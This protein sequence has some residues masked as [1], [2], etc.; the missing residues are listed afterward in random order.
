[1]SNNLGLPGCPHALR[2]TRTEFTWAWVGRDRFAVL[3]AYAREY[4]DP[5]F[6]A[7]PSRA[8]PWLRASAAP[9]RR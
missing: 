3:D 6:T 9:R 8:R 4:I 7:L 1:M 2:Q 5:G